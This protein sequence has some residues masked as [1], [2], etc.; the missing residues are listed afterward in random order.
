M[1]LQV[2][3]LACYYAIAIYYPEYMQLCMHRTMTT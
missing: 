3:C 1:L 2:R